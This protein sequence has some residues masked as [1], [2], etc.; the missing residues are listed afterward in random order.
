[1]RRFKERAPTR[2][3]AIIRRFFAGIS[4]RFTLT[5]SPMLD[6]GIGVYSLSVHLQFDRTEILR[7]N[8]K[9][10]QPAFARASAYA[11]LYERFCNRYGTTGYLFDDPAEET[12]PSPQRLALAF[13][14]FRGREDAFL[15][16]LTAECPAVREKTYLPIAAEDAPLSVDPRHIFTYCGTNGMAAG[17]TLEEALVQGISELAERH[18]LCRCLWDASLSLKEIPD[19]VLATQ[20]PE[21][22]EKIRAVR[23]AGFSLRFFDAADAT[24]L[25]V[26]LSLWVSR[27]HGVHVV[28]F[29]AFPVFSVAVER[30]ITEA[31]Q[32]AGCRIMRSL[33]RTR[34]TRVPDA[35]SFIRCSNT[36]T[37]FCQSGC[38]RTQSRLRRFPPGSICADPAAT[39]ICWRI[40]PHWDGQAVFICIIAMCR[41]RRRWRRYR[42]SAR[43]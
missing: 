21:S 8:G 1:M 24:G 3:V 29:G 4:K 43:S 23:A 16:Y 10:M 39:G 19:A 31:M 17:N 34:R 35:W 11:E 15:R 28:K 33:C 40:L 2:T 26:V 42:P 36:E 32:G 38:S 37:G 20:A 13:P 22:F 27:A 5:E 14:A 7:T 18:V 25:P 41:S 6:G 9:G 12:T 30:C